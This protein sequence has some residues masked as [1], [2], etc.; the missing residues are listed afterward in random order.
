MPKQLKCPVCPVCSNDSLEE[1]ERVDVGF[2]TAMGV[3]C[4]PDHCNVCGYVEAGP[5]PHDPPIEYFKDC[6]AK[7]INPNSNVLEMKRASLSQEHLDW[8]QNNVKDSYGKCLFYTAKLQEQFPNLRRVYGF[9]YCPIWGERNHF[10][11]ITEQN[12][13][14][15]PTASQFPS[16][17]TGSYVMIRF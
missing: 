2:G 7:G 16:K 6:W 8:I 3:K 5:D 11:C 13:V 9:Y 15:D 12:T 17:G 1:G 4:G 14:V 10:W